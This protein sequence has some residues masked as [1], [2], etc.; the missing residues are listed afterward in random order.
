LNNWGC[1]VIIQEFPEESIDFKKISTKDC[2]ELPAEKL[3]KEMWYFEVPKL[4]ASDV[5][6]AIQRT[7]KEIDTKVLSEIKW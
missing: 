5:Q 7:D 1:N 4:K 2:N 6:K 3:S